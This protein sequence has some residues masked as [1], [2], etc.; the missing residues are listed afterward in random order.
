MNAAVKAV[1]KNPVYVPSNKLLVTPLPL[2]V[3]HDQ[4]FNDIEPKPLKLKGALLERTEK[5]LPTLLLKPNEVNNAIRNNAAMSMIEAF[6][7]VPFVKAD[8]NKHR[9]FHT[10]IKKGSILANISKYYYVIKHVK[11]IILTYTAVT[12]TEVLSG[13]VIHSLGRWDIEIDDGY[14]EEAVEFFMKA[15]KSV[16]CSDTEKSAYHLLTDLIFA[17]TPYRT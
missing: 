4:F 17:L 11:G 2:S 7:R 10:A 8:Y 3:M 9:I 1:R 14:P 13:E 5:Y 6:N 12:T 16:V 15:V